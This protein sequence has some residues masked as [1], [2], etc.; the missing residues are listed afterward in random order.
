MQLYKF[1]FH[2]IFNGQDILESFYHFTL[3]GR[4]KK[5]ET[6]NIFGGMAKRS[7]LSAAFC[8]LL[9][10]GIKIHI[11]S[12]FF[13]KMKFYDLSNNGKTKGFIAYFYDMY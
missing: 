11:Y 6:L 9:P 12:S 5:N 7:I 13:G 1:Y 2:F 3:D 8:S 4:G 10:G